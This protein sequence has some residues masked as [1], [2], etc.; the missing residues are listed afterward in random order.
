MLTP[1]SLPSLQ[2]TLAAIGLDGW[3]LFD[4]QGTNPIAA[5]VLGLRGMV[6]RRVFALI[7]REGAPVA[8]THE[9]EQGPWR[10]WPAAWKRERYGSW[11]ALESLLARLV[12]GKRI[13]MEYSPGDAVPYVDRIPAGVLEL[14]R[15]AGATVVSSAELVT[16][17]YAVWTA[18]HLASHRR[19]AKIVATAARE[20]LALAGA[21]ARTEAPMAEHE[22]QSWLS[23]RLHRDGLEFDHPPI[24]A[25]GAN[26][27]DAHYAPS[28]SRPRPIQPGDV[29]L[30]DLWGKEPRGVYADQTWMASVGEPSK[31]A[32]SVWEAVRDARDAAISLLRERVTAGTPLKGADLDDAARGVIAARG[33]G[34]RFVHRTGHSIDP[35]S[36]HGAGPHLDNFETR[37]ERQLLPGVGFSIE[38]GIYVPGEIGV[39]SE[40]NAWVGDG[41][42]VITPEDPQRELIRV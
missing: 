10:D 6:T 35:R 14:V 11:K 38:P 23:D 12:G 5:G 8:V 16:R 18:D 36:L 34:D 30:V 28:S 32:V 3:L 17:F 25:V 39:R 2:R 7:P 15:H 33:F 13:A 27:A 29:V 1:E 19:A 4:F 20:G 41:S 22:L 9:I 40:V 24:V 26:A 42:V 37:E 31:R 21:R